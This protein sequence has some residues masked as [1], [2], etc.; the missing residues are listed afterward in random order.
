MKT[1]LG[2][3]EQIGQLYSRYSLQVTIVFR[4]ILAWFVFQTINSNLGYMERLNSTAVVLGLSILCALLPLFVLVFWAA[5]LI[6]AHLYALATAIMVIVLLV[7]II[8]YI[9]YFR[10]TPGKTWTIL[11]VPIAFFFDLPFVIPVIFGLLGTP[12]LIVPAIAGTVVYYILEYI[13]TT[14]AI[15]AVEGI[16]EM[17]ELSGVFV[18][19]I[20]VNPEQWMVGFVLGVG[21][22]I[23]YAL[24]TRSFPHCW[25][26]AFIFGAIWVH[27]AI[28][29]G[30]SII[31]I[32][33]P[34]FVMLNTILAIII[35]FLLEFFFHRV[36][37]TRTE[38]LQF[39]DNEYYYYVKAIP[40]RFSHDI[41]HRDGARPPRSRSHRARGAAGSSFDD[42]RRKGRRVD[43]GT[44]GMTG[45]ATGETGGMTGRT[46]GG[47]T[48]GLNSMLDM[49]NIKRKFGKDGKSS[50]GGNRSG[51]MR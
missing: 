26:V 16:P 2:L 6:L 34:G 42:S 1:I 23:I 8:L 37:Y 49:D 48:G 19:T 27:V 22:M 47:I 44:G 36:D 11:L 28:V 17:I 14:E 4:F 13:Q 20:L 10:F 38:Y 7:F 24:R 25:K 31:E 18:M 41:D 33:P 51:K 30:S 9:F 5:V 12:V 39:D 46:T 43:G 21:T 3:R 40:K 35:G 32:N 15:Y 45:R 29:V 50:D